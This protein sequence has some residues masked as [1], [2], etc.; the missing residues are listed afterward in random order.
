MVAKRYPCPNFVL[1][2]FISRGL[3]TEFLHKMY[4]LVEEDTTYEFWL[5]KVNDKTY[6]DFKRSL[7]RPTAKVIEGP[8]KE[9]VR[10]I[11]METKRMLNPNNKFVEGVLK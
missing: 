5:H 4:E 11:V 2:G 9:E 8:S 1:D 3:L 6:N 7:H 10:A